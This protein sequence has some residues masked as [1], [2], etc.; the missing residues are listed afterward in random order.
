MFSALKNFDQ[1][2]G[3]LLSNC[4]CLDGWA[5]V[6]MT[7][8]LFYFPHALAR[9]PN[10][11][12]SVVFFGK[13]GLHPTEFFVA[14]SIIVEILAGVCLTLN[15][16]TRWAAVLSAGTLLVAGYALVAVGG[17]KWGWNGGGIEYVA[18]WIL[19]SLAIAVD[20]WKKQANRS[21]Q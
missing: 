16:L 12:N 1:R 17:L 6:R 4:T 2:I 14:L 7:C 21:S 10:F 8:G 15:V 19:I 13:A 18:F 11:Q 9:I 5:V 20:D 3:R